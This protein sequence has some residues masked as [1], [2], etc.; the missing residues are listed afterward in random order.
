MNARLP[1]GAAGQILA[2][3]PGWQNGTGVFPGWVE[4]TT[5]TA[6]S[7]ANPGHWNGTPP[8]TL[9]E[10]GDRLAALLSNNGANPI[11]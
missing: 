7:P 3:V 10:M 6:Y 9:A 5:I 8:A 4:P 11:P 1:I 2:A